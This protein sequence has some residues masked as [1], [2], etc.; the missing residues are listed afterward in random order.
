MLCN[1]TGS[2]LKRSTKSGGVA[3]PSKP[4]VYLRFGPLN[5]FYNVTGKWKAIVI[6][7]M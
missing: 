7:E 6:N 3:K 2:I 1:S 5:R 4:A